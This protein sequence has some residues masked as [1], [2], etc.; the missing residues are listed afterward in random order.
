MLTNCECYSTLAPRLRSANTSLSYNFCWLV[1]NLFINS[2]ASDIQLYFFYETKNCDNSVTETL[3]LG[4]KYTKYI[5]II[6]DGK[7]TAMYIN[8]L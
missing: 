4:R 2:N 6:N 8:V 1:S 3:F 5:N 7:P